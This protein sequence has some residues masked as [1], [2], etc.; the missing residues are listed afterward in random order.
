M[1][2]HAEYYPAAMKHLPAVVRTKAIEIANAL[3]DQGYDEGKAIRIAVA[4]AKAW[5]AA[6]PG[7]DFQS[8]FP[9][10]DSDADP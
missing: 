9:T 3:L 1:P 4:K 7:I 10:G 6:H 8:D 5:A 2:W